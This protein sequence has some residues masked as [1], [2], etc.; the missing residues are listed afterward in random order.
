MSCHQLAE[1]EGASKVLQFHCQQALNLLVEKVMDGPE[2]TLSVLQVQKL[3]IWVP[4]DR[5]D[6]AT[7]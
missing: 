7:S 6:N 2:L 4:S 1:L 5:F 3:I